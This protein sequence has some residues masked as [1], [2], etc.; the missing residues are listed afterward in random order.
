ML[1]EGDARDTLPVYAEQHQAVALVV[2]SRGKGAVS[3]ALLGSVSTYLI[4][5]SKTPVVVVHHKKTEDK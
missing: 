2:G 4:H 5:H 3:R 1:I